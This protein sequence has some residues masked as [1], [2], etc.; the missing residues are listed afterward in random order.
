MNSPY[1]D[2]K[3]S[4]LLGHDIQGFA[5]VQCKGPPNTFVVMRLKDDVG[6]E[7]SSMLLAYALCARCG[8]L[9]W[10]QAGKKVFASLRESLVE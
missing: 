4:M 2:L 10:E 1:T 9:Y 8:S 5:C 7:K 3:C 6:D